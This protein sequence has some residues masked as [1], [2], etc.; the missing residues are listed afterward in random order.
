MAQRLQNITIQAPGFAGLNT[1]DSPIGLDASFAAIADNC[2][3]DQL[4]RV[5]ARKGY[6]AV[7]TNG[8]SVLGTSRGIEAVHEF[9]SST[10]TKVVFSAGN[11]KIFTGTSTLAEVTLP[12]GY[13]ITANNWKIVS[14]NNN[15]YFFQRGHAALVSAAGSTTLTKVV[16]GSHYAPEANEVI[17]AYGRL[18]AADITGNKKTVYW[19]DLLNGNNWHGGSS[20]SLDLTK[21]FPTGFDEIVALSAHN[22]FLIIFG[23]KSILVY[24]GA[25]VP[26]SDTAVFKIVDTV[27]GVGCIE[28]D[29]VQHTGTDILFLS[30][31]GVRSFSRTVQEKS[32][33]MRDISKNIRN[34]L[35]E[36]YTQQN[37]PVKSLYSPEEAFYLLTL[38]DSN[39]TYCFD[40]R[41]ELPDGSQRVTTWSDITPLSLTRL[42]DGTIYLGKS[43]GIKT[44]TGHLDGTESYIMSYFSNPL[45]F[46]DASRLKFLKKFNLTVIGNVSAV[47][48][49]NWGYDYTFDY[50][51][52]SFSSG[53][54]NTTQAEY[55]V[56]EFGDNTTT[57]ITPNS[58]ATYLGAFS[59]AP[60]TSEVNA[61][62][63]NTTDGKLYYWSG[64]AWVEET[65]LNTNFVSSEYTTGVDIQLP[66]VSGT[67]SGSVVTVGVESTINGAPY[68]IQKLDI[69]ALLGRLI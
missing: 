48:V 28:R 11:N 15:V 49:L 18:W 8:S 37:N 51:K 32:M 17:G 35:A 9:V 16:D 7:S 60:T 26:S 1:Q 68:S 64:S 65:T 20:G 58:T 69:H 22:G 10:G 12:V 6:Q 62:Y 36:F 34:D 27:E 38:P 52:Q 19:S 2:V 67:G 43:D 21:V 29:S 31:M 45:D 14:F 55:N 44:Y 66:E 40:M 47:T 59:S 24:S 4:G 41:T 5:G 56:S 33:P 30:E 13:S 46:G 23:K 61:L 57:L 54:T 63:Y 3:I 39:T 53:L 25:D 50:Q 42:D